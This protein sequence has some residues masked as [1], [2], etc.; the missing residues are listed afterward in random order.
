MI[1]LGGFA[2]PFQPDPIITRHPA[3]GK[4]ALG[5]LGLRFTTAADRRLT[6]ELHPFGFI[7]HHPAPDQITDGQ[8]QLRQRQ[9]LISGAAVPA[10]SF[11]VITRQSAPFGV[12]PP[13]IAGP[14]ESI[15][16]QSKRGRRGG[17]QTH[18][19]GEIVVP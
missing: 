7:Q 11:P 5:Q 15:R 14:G 1:L 10:Q 8:L 13:Q 18:L 9:I 12:H 17:D 6:Q 16:Q 2:Q 3:P 4:I 19:A